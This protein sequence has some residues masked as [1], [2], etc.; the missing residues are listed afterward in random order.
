MWLHWWGLT[1]IPVPKRAREK[2][3]VEAARIVHVVNGIQMHNCVYVNGFPS[4]ACVQNGV[5]GSNMH[6]LSLPVSLTL[7]SHEMGLRFIQPLE[8]DSALT[9]WLQG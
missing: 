5:S 8:I 1:F 2:E 3:C 9:V 6:A 7:T 4:K